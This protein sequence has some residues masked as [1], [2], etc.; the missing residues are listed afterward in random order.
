MDMVVR[1]PLPEIRDF[2]LPT[3]GKVRVM[4]YTQFDIY[5]LIYL[6]IAIIMGSY[7]GFSGELGATIKLFVTLF[8]SYGIMYLIRDKLDSSLINNFLVPMILFSTVYL[9]TGFVIKFFTNQLVTLIRVILPKFVDKPL[10]VLLA[11]T[12]ASLII[13][14]VLFAI[15]KLKEVLNLQLPVWIAE[16]Q[17]NQFASEYYGGLTKKV[18]GD[19]N[20]KKMILERL[21]KQKSD[22]KDAPK[23][24]NTK[25]F[26][27]LSKQDKLQ[28]LKGLLKNYK[29]PDKKKAKEDEKLKIEYETLEELLKDIE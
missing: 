23:V 2:D 11:L 18:V 4:E 8:L 6:G 29:T 12:K 19:K 24:K 9:I 28:L 22:D 17:T 25:E 5:I 10:G 13:F 14:I 16:S 1:K 27:D 3:E 7:R 20:A 21:L 15:D 26:D